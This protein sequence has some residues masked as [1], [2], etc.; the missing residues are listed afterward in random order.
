MMQNGPIPGNPALRRGRWRRAAPVGLSLLCMAVP[1]RGTPAAPPVTRD[2]WL[3]DAKVAVQIFDCD[4]LSCG[5]VTWMVVPRD[6]QGAL[7]RDWRNPDP[8][9]RQRQLCGLTIL[10]GLHPTGA[11]RWEAG[12]FYNPLDG[13]TYRVSAKRASADRIVARV[14]L[15]IPFFGQT[16]TLQRVAHRTEEGWC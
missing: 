11:D 4:G 3:M 16:K 15:G 13:N 6:A 1:V 5:R 12:W 8:A 2:V 9:L 7:N 14:Y 10:W